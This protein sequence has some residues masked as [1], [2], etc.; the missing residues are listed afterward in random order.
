M[1]GDEIREDYYTDEPLPEDLKIDNRLIAPVAVK[2]VEGY[3]IKH[4]V[5]NK[6]VNDRYHSYIRFVKVF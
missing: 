1:K 5:L 6:K 3:M 4:M 2:R